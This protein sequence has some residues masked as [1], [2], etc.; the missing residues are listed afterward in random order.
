MR[1][2]PGPAPPRETG[3]DSART[4]TR[5]LRLLRA[6]R[7]AALRRNRGD[8]AYLVYLAVFVG[9][10]TIPP[11]VF[12]VVDAVTGPALLDPWPPHRFVALVPLFLAG[13]LGLLWASAREATVRGPI[14]V[15]APVIDWILPLPVDRSRLL[16]P[17]LLRSAATRGAAGAVLGPLLLVLLW[18]TVLPMPTPVE[19]AVTSGDGAAWVLLAQAAVAGALAGLSSSACGALVVAFGPRALRK[20]RPW[21]ALAQLLL[22]GA[23]V[24]AWTLPALS[25]SPLIGQALRVGAWA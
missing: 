25:T 20:A 7:R 16:S 6:H 15:S 13:L 11:A 21:H 3:P 19:G 24:L 4:T 2:G 18:R 23:A 12:A 8:A 14:Q 17:A 5:V 9:G 1:G 10:L 22:V